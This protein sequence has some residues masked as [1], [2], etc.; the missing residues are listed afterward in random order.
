MMFSGFS[1]PIYEPEPM[2]QR[3]ME[4]LLQLSELHNNIVPQSEKGEV[5]ID[6]IEE[7]M[8]TVFNQLTEG[9]V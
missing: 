6:K 3:I 7:R 8:L 5:L 4:H 2:F 1:K 9:Q